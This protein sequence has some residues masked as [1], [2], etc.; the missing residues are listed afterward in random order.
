MLFYLDN[1]QSEGPDSDAAQDRP[2]AAHPPGWHP[3]AVALHPAPQGQ[4]PNAQ[5][6]PQKHR[7][8][9]NENY[10]R[11][12]MELHTLGVN[13]GY[14]QQDVTEVA[15]VFTG[16]TLEE[17]RRGGG[18]VFRPRLHEPGNKVVL[19]HTIK[20][21]GESEGLEVLDLLAHSPATA[22]FICTELAQRFVSDNPPPS[23]IDGCRRHSSRAMA[24]SRSA[25]RPCSARPSSGRPKPTAPGSRPRWNSSP[26][27]C[28]RR[29]LRSPTLSR[30]W[31]TE[32]N[33]PA[34]ATA[35]TSHRL[36]D[37]CRC[38]GEL[39]GPARPH[40]LRTCAGEQPA[41]PEPISILRN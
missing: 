28:A 22:R 21:D 3:R 40:E 32:Q 15:R 11:E 6:N 1:W 5:N 23:L 2:A 8:G 7:S 36:F 13:G 29:R 26:L 4:Q 39:G 19:G 35:A 41:C 37:E 31:D 38:V 9:L 20:D 12:L 18:F 14:T 25:S 16:W 10:A 27:P 24:I 30:C 34:A 17:P 33:G